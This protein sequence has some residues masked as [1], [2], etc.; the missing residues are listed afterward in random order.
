MKKF[1]CFLLKFYQLFS[2]WMPPSC[3]FYP[4]CSNY[5]LEAVTKHGTLKGMH[6]AFLRLLKCHPYHKGGYDPVP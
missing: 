4:T 5:A 2:K 6:L 3:R 1:I